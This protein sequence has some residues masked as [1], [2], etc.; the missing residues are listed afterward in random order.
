[1]DADTQQV[2]IYHHQNPRFWESDGFVT[3][4]DFALVAEI[5]FV[6]P[7]PEKEILEFCYRITNNVEENWNERFC[8][9]SEPVHFQQYVDG[10]TYSFVTTIHTERFGVG[11]GCPFRSSSVGDCFV[12]GGKT[13]EVA[14]I[15]FKEVE[16]R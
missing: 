11:A 4:S 7:I 10:P 13:H 5:S 15:G 9:G 2:K 8:N 6:T 14:G 12:T 3:M 16:A 1:M